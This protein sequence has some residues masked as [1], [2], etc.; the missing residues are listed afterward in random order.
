MHYIIYYILYILYI[1]IL[2]IYIY[3]LALFSL[4][5]PVVNKIIQET[6]E[7]LVIRPL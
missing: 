1:Y 3:S 4:M 6:N 5:W 2:Y 7:A